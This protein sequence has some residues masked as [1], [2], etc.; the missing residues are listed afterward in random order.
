MFQCPVNIEVEAFRRFLDE[1]GQSGTDEV[2]ALLPELCPDLFAG[3]GLRLDRLNSRVFRVRSVLNDEEISVVLKRLKPSLAERNEFIIRRWLPGIGLP[4]VAPALLGKIGDGR[5]T[6]VWNVYEDVGTTVL[7]A[8]N[9]QADAVAAVLE[10]VA[11]LH[12]RAAGAPL[13][14]EC[15]QHLEDLGIRYFISSVGD[16]IA[17][18]EA[19]RA[20]EPTFTTPQR[21]VRDRLLERLRTLIESGPLR[22]QLMRELGGPPTLLHGDLWTINTLVI[23]GSNGMTAR[24]IDWDRAGVGPV[25][26]D[27]STFLYRFPCG[28]RRWILNEYRNAIGRAGWYLPEDPDLNVLFD[29]AECARYAS[30]IIWP[31]AALLNERA[32]SGHSELAQILGWFDALEPVLPN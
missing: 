14:T 24:L 29:T 8:R 15:R 27:L 11:Q 18:L 32:E 26:Y 22:A 25:A 21:V 9:P 20:L 4:N 19:L 13:L 31:A 12:T 28:E 10:S 1:A 5:S 23:P 3:S 6:C 16:A 17:S 7:N 30:R 2:W